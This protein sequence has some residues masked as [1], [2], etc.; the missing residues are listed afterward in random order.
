MDGNKEIEWNKERIFFS[1]K[2][3]NS[4]SNCPKRVKMKTVQEKEDVS[5]EDAS[6][7]VQ[8]IYIDEGEGDILITGDSRWVNVK[9]REHEEDLS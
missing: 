4:K 9:V 7:I 6:P 8:P 1:Y 3:Y 2:K 5:T